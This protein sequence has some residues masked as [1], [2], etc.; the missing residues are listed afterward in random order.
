MSE[1]YSELVQIQ[2]EGLI[3]VPI[4]ADA[5]GN[6]PENSLHVEGGQ[7]F[8]KIRTSE[9]AT[10][11][12]PSPPVTQTTKDVQTLSLEQSKGAPTSDRSIPP[13]I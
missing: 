8:K 11:V 9:F 13:T 1:T 7:P 12:A 5:N 2:L 4:S 6:I 10:E 3:D